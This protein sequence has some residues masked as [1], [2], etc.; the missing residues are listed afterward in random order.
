[1]AVQ[2]LF[3][4][5][6]RLKRGMA[7]ASGGETQSLTCGKEGREMTMSTVLVILLVLLLIAA[8]PIYP[9]SRGWGYFPSG[10]LAVIVAV[11]ALMLLL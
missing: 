5:A 11:M 1:V 3:P 4:K 10:I 2:S 8:L 7:V 9:Y 6:V